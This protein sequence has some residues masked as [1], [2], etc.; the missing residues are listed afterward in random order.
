MK[1]MII[2]LIMMSLIGSMMWVMPT[3]RQKYQAAL[4]MK[5]KKQGFQIQLEK[6]TPPR[7]KGELESDSKEMTAYRVLRHGL[8]QNEKNSFRAWHIYRV[9]SIADIG[10]PDGWS[11]G[12]GERTLSEEELAKI[13]Q[14]ISDLPGGVFSIESSAVYLGVHWDEEGG[15]QAMAAIHATLTRF[16]DNKL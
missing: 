11:W 13:N 16:L 15:E 2:V 5:A 8:K 10:L 3:K 1:W 6:V 12:S 14:L 4:R 9:E 7:A